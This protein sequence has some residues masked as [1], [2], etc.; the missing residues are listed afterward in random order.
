M[1]KAGQIVGQFAK[2][3]AN[4]ISDKALQPYDEVF[5][6]QRFR[7]T[8]LIH[9]RW[10]QHPSQ[11]RGHVIWGTVSCK[12]VL[13]ALMAGPCACAVVRLCATSMTQHV[14]ALQV[15]YAGNPRSHRRRGINR[16]FLVRPFS[17]VLT[18]GLGACGP[19]VLQWLHSEQHPLQSV[20][21]ERAPQPR[22]KAF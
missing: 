20:Y 8:E 12:P 6:L 11:Q 2:G 10:V 1:N 16:C 14:L 19:L 4:Q 21:L 3:K 15:G 18:C 5:G 13:T 17:H 7:E 9:G 22:L